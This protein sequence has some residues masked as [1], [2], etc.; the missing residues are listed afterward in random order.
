MRELTVRV[1][2]TGDAYIATVR[3]VATGALLDAPAAP[4]TTDS[5]YTAQTAAGAIVGAIAAS[6][7]DTIPVDKRL[8]PTRPTHGGYPTV[9]SPTGPEAPETA[10]IELSDV[11]DDAGRTREAFLEA[12]VDIVSVLGAADIGAAAAVNLDRLPASVIVAGENAMKFLAAAVGILDPDAT[13]L[14]GLDADDILE[15]WTG[16]T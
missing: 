5:H 9:E 13:M 2:A 1:R 10:R 6:T 7:L 3:Q 11:A 4:G 12:M 8:P 15:R 16:G 14:E